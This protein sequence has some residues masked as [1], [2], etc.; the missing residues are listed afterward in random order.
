MYSDKKGKKWKIAVLAVL[1]AACIFLIW[2]FIYRSP[3]AGTGEEAA[4]SIKTAVQQCALQC[5]TV[6]GAYPPNL[7]YLEDNYGLRVNTT[8]FYV[9][10][11]AFAENQMPDVR[12]TK[13]E[14]K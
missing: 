6:E 9:T 2:F 11:E 7:E 8:D 14:H 10:Y 4:E 3:A 1:A 13:R 5:Y 12:V